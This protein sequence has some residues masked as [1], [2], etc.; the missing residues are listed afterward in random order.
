MSFANIPFD[1]S[2]DIGKLHTELKKSLQNPQQSVKQE[3]LDFL[4]SLE[5]LIGKQP[6]PI[7]QSSS[8]S[9]VKTTGGIPVNIES[10]DRPRGVYGTTNIVSGRSGKNKDA[11][12]H[13]NRINSTPVQNVPV[14]ADPSSS[15]IQASKGTPSKG[16]NSSDLETHPT[17][18]ATAALDEENITSHITKLTQN[19]PVGFSKPAAINAQAQ[20]SQSGGGGLGISKGVTTESISQVEAPEPPTK[21]TTSQQEEEPKSS[22]GGLGSA[23]SSILGDVGAVAEG[24][25]GDE[26][27]LENKLTSGLSKAGDAANQVD[28]GADDKTGEGLQKAAGLSGGIAAATSWIPGVGELAEGISGLL[29]V[30]SSLYDIFHKP[31]ANSV[32]RPDPVE[33]TETNALDF[34]TAGDTSGAIGVQA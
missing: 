13:T 14:V 20:P 5:S 6:D 27:P 19:N 17:A 24:V 1:E 11:Q 23:L 31:E 8:R 28:P 16:I 26:E 22:G 3:N 33:H 21:S 7:L 29:G 15:V 18:N 34:T 12:Q 30:G 32:T 25:E 2:T 9:S 10:I 4:P